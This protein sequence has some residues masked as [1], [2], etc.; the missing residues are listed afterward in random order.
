LS[1]ILLFMQVQYFVMTSTVAFSSLLSW[2]HWATYFASS[3]PARAAPPPIDTVAAN[4]R[5]AAI[6][7]MR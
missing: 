2:T 1:L 5:A 3:G 4:N 6:E 7:S